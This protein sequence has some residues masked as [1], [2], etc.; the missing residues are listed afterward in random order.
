M[1]ATLGNLVW[2]I[3]TGVAMV[4]AKMTVVEAI[5]MTILVFAG[6]AQLAVLPLLLLDAPLGIILLTAAIVNL[7][8]VIYAATLAPHF[9]ALSRFRRLVLGYFG[10]DI[11]FVV[12]M[13]RV[14]LEP[15]RPYPQAFYLGC[16]LGPWFIWELGSMIG[17]ALGAGI[18]PD[19]GLEFGGTLALLALTIPLI[20]SWPSAIGVVAAATSSIAWVHWPYRVGLVCAVLTGIAFAMATESIQARRNAG[21]TL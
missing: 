2:G 6:S 11:S 18:P 14:T 3:I 8:F 19:W 13:Q 5:G 1:P 17:I 10:G 9:A 21:R 7:R 4:K 16:A 15:E 20:Q 12:F